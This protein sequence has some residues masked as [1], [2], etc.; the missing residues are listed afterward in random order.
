MAENKTYKKIEVVGTSEESVSDAIE[1]A[2]DKAEESVENL[3]WFEVDEI[4]GGL[5]GGTL[6]YQVSVEIGFRLE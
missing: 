5:T 4:R 2:I 1:G 3:D 6:T